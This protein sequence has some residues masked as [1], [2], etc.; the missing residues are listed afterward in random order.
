MSAAKQ[1]LNVVHLLQNDDNILVGTTVVPKG[2]KV[3]R[4]TVMQ[5]LQD[6]IWPDNVLFSVFF[7]E[8]SKQGIWHYHG[9]F[10]LRQFTKS[11]RHKTLTFRNELI[12]E[13]L[14][15]AYYI[16]KDQPTRMCIRRK[17]HPIVFITEQYTEVLCYLNR[18]IP[19]IKHYTIV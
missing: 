3:S 15:W 18:E 4:N 12:N 9:Y 16:I 8:K 13:L 2:K 7:E 10:L 17:G 5:R 1:L 19:K 11:L 6:T 14:S